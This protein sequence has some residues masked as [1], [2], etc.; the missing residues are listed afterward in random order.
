MMPYE[1]L[2]PTHTAYVV[3]DRLFG[4]I[5]GFDDRTRAAERLEETWRFLSEPKP[6]IAFPRVAAGY[7]FMESNRDISRENHVPVGDDALRCELPF[8]PDVQVYV[9]ASRFPGQSYRL[10]EPQL[11]IFRNPAGSYDLHLEENTTLREFLVA[12]SLDAGE[13]FGPLHRIRI[14]PMEIR[15]VHAAHLDAIHEAAATQGLKCLPEIEA[16]IENQ[17]GMLTFGQSSAPVPRGW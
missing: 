13:T 4:P 1:P 11:E 17:Q 3:D 16:A 14:A 6:G 12:Q 15:T 9:L 10:P 8:G 7:A 2:Q 5:R